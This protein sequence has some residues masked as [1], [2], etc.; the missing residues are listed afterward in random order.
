MPEFEEMSVRIDSLTL[1]PRLQMRE[2]DPGTH[3]EFPGKLR[4]KYLG[5]VMEDVVVDY[6]NKVDELDPIDVI[7]NTEEGGQGERWVVDGFNTLAAWEL[8]E[9]QRQFVKC[10]V[11]KGD[12]KDAVEY[13]AGA[14]IKHGMPLTSVGKMRAVVALLE[15]EG[16]ASRSVRQLSKAT[17]C[18]ERFVN[19]VREE[20]MQE[21]ARKELAAKRAEDQKAE[22]DKE[23]KPRT[24]KQRV[25]DKRV[26][27]KGR[28]IA[29]KEVSESQTAS[30]RLTG[31]LRDF[32]DLCR[33][34]RRKL[35]SIYRAAGRTGPDKA[36]AE[37]SLYADVAGKLSAVEKLVEKL[38]KQTV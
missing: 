19:N 4:K 6:A 24:V 17:G 21:R 15:L 2:P 31:Y 5:L 20:W 30:N 13:A 37:D 11:A 28:R 34:A 27:T 8:A 22:P 12:W 9:P 29:L 10:R 1:D 23:L 38:K 36:I 35:D 25:E 26:D 16:G 7:E 33:S 14:N 3:T 32:R 18:T